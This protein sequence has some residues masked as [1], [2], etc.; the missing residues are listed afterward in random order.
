[1]SKT[2]QLNIKRVP[3]CRSGYTKRP[4]CS[5][6]GGRWLLQQQSWRRAYPAQFSLSSMLNKGELKRSF[7]G[8]M[9]FLSPTSRNHSLDLEFGRS[10]SNSTS[11]KNGPSRIAFQG[12]LMASEPTWIDQLPIIIINI[13][14]IRKQ[15]MQRKAHYVQRA[16]L[17]SWRPIMHKIMCVHNHIMP[18]Y[19]SSNHF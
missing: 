17:C 16:K 11:W 18:G 6:S 2:Y 10:V 4:R 5:C 13:I 9:A 3:D 19:L 15:I 14:I 7:C 8:R 12:H 1:M